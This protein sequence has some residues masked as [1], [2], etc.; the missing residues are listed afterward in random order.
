MKTPSNEVLRPTRA[1]FVQTQTPTSSIT[2]N[3]TEDM[4]SFN[5]KA[6][7]VAV[8]KIEDG[9]MVTGVI[10]FTTLLESQG[11]LFT[12][13]N[14]VP[15]EKELLIGEDYKNAQHNNTSR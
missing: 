3:F 1:I 6:E 15:F 5:E 12:T 13:K 4:M 11:K 8:K 10:S 9:V 14:Q 2:L 7:V